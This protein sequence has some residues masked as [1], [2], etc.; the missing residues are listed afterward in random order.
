[1]AAAP[2]SFKIYPYP[3][4]NLTITRVYGGTTQSVTATHLALNDY[5]DVSSMEGTF[6]ISADGYETQ[7][8]QQTE[9]V[10]NDVTLVEDLPD[11]IAD[12]ITAAQGRV[13]NCYTAISNKGGT[14]PATQ[15]LANMPTAIGSIPT[16]STINNQDITITQNG[17]YTADEGYTGLGTVTVNVNKSKFGITIDDL[18]GDLVSGKYTVKTTPIDVSFDGLTSF[19]KLNGSSSDGTWVMSYLFTNSQC[20]RS[21]TFPSLTAVSG[22][23]YDC[24]SHFCFYSKSVESVS[25]PVLTSLSSIRTFES[26][27]EGCI[28]LS[29]VSFPVLA[30]SN[31]AEVFNRAFA[32]CIRLKTISFPSLATTEY[33]VFRYSF[34]GSALETIDFASLNA[35]GKTKGYGFNYAFTGCNTLQSI[36]FPALKTDSFGTSYTNQFQDMFDSI[37][38]QTSGNVVVHFPSNLETTIQGLTGYPLFGGTSGRITLS[39]DLEATA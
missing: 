29:S 12:A 15:N 22:A 9:Y 6:T 2:I 4:T 10:T 14:L 3:L 23:P 18:I 27:F 31:S 7:T 13:A 33:A 38:A 25:F 26:A 17:T 32:G 28:K 36:S 37:T 19:Q 24:L 35:V 30:T 39:F 20:I 5:Y 21:V 34:S 16:G 11:N 8:I 1:M